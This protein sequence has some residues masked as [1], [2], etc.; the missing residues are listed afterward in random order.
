[1]YKLLYEI[2]IFYIIG[3]IILL[4]VFLF[5]SITTIFAVINAFRS[6]SKIIKRIMLT[7]VSV[8]FTFGT[9]AIFF[10]TF[11]NNDNPYF[12]YKTNNY[13]TVEGK[14]CN[15]ERNEGSELKYEEFKVNN[16]TFEYGIDISY[17]YNVDKAKGHKCKNG[18]YVKIGYVY[19][20]TQNVNTI[21]KFE[22]RED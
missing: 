15:Y 6:H 4:I 9:V 14:I 10:F 22:I 3:M 18:D 17:G 20:E 11:I 2:S 12:A 21:V 7:I 1:M 16:V 13:K 5:L 8:G 19:D